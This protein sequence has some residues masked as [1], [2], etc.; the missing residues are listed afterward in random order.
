MEV[1]AKKDEGS[2]GHGI[3]NERNGHT[4]RRPAI[5]VPNAAV[6]GSSSVCSGYDCYCIP[7]KHIVGCDFVFS[8]G[9][10]SRCLALSGGSCP[11]SMNTGA[12]M[13]RVVTLPSLSLRSLGTTQSSYAYL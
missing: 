5:N 7:R 2:F 11:S 12:K 1:L 10:I 13:G 4:I 8:V 3:L 6:V 9:M